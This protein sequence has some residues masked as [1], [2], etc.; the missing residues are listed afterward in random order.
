[1][2][3]PLLSASVAELDQRQQPRVS[4]TNY[5]PKYFRPLFDTNEDTVHRVDSARTSVIDDM[6]VSELASEQDDALPPPIT[7][8]F[9]AIPRIAAGI[10]AINEEMN[11]TEEALSVNSTSNCVTTHRYID[12]AN[13]VK[14]QVAPLVC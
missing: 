6:S 5:A 2:A 4:S 10:P 3:S 7:N 1:M 13:V 14:I 8:N 12:E 11:E 9:M